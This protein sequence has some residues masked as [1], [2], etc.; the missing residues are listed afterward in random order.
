MKVNYPCQIVKAFRDSVVRKNGGFS[1]KE[2]QI[3]VLSSVD[4]DIN[5][6]QR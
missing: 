2:I 4:I 3:P 6:E 1:Y 5:I